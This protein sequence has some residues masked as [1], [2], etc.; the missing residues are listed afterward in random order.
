MSTPA[1]LALCRCHTRG[2]DPLPT[3]LLTVATDSS[4]PIGVSRVHVRNRVNPNPAVVNRIVGFRIG[5][6]LENTTFAPNP[7]VPTQDFGTVGVTNYDFNFNCV[8]GSPTSPT[9]QPSAG[10]TDAPSDAPT[11]RPTTLPPSRAPT[12]LPT[13]TPTHAPTLHPTARPSRLPTARPTVSPTAAPTEQ[14][15]RSPTNGPTD[16]PTDGPTGAPTA[17]P[18]HTPT[19]SPT[20]PPTPTAAASSGGGGGGSPVIYAVVGVVALLLIVVGVLW[21]RARNQDKL[22]VKPRI[23]QHQNPAYIS[24][25]PPAMATAAESTAHHR[26]S[27]DSGSTVPANAYAN[28]KEHTAVTTVFR[29]A[30]RT[31]PANETGYLTVHDGVAYAVPFEANQGAAPT[32]HVLTRIPSLDHHM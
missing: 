26:G 19:T 7:L 17:A 4:S 23:H 18:T 6:Y 16:A 1:A 2:G 15:S 31:A 32:E 27:S 24:T 29:A 3:L 10:P 9:Q 14:P 22:G 28:P 8:T 25:V 21:L 11:S 5:L 13:R 12:R 30:S 20:L